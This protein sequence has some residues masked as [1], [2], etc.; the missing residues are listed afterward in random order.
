MCFICR[1]TLKTTT[2]LRQ[3]FTFCH[4][5]QTERFHCLKCD[6]YFEKV[7]SYIK[8]LKTLHEYETNSSHAV[9]QQC[10]YD[11]ENM[12][13]LDD[14][15]V[16]EEKQCLNAIENLPN[17]DDNSVYEEQC[18]FQDSN[19]PSVTEKCRTLKD[20]LIYT[21]TN[22]QTLNRKMIV[23]FLKE[24]SLFSSNIVN[25]LKFSIIDYLDDITNL[26]N[27]ET[28]HV[29]V[30]NLFDEALAS[31]DENISEHRLFKKFADSNCYIEPQEYIIAQDIQVKKNMLA[32]APIV[33]HHVPL[34]H[35][36]KHILEIPGVFTFALDYLSSNSSNDS[37]K[38]FCD[39]KDGNL[40]HS[41]KSNFVDKIVFPFFIY[42]DD[43]ECL[44]PL[45][46]HSGLHKLG[47]VYATLKCFPPEMLSALDNIYLT[48][49]FHADDRRNYKNSAVFD[50]LLKEIIDL[51]NNG[52]LINNGSET[53]QVYFVLGL[54]I[55]D[56]LAMHSLLGLV[57][58][59]SSNKVCRVCT[60]DK[61]Q[62]HTLTKESPE[63]LRNETQ[64]ED[65]CKSIKTFDS[66]L[67]EPCI[68]HKV[69]SFHLTKNISFDIC[70]DIWEGICS[71]DMAI[72]IEKFIYDDC[73]KFFDLNYLNDKIKYTAYVFD[74]TNKPPPI[75]RESLQKG[76]LKM[77][78]AETMT[79]IHY[80]R[81]YVGDCVPIDN[82]YWLLYLNLLHICNTV[83]S[84]CVSDPE[85][86]LL[87]SVIEEHH[88]RYCA[89]I[90]NLKPKYHY[91]L[92]YARTIR[93]SGNLNAMSTIRF[94]SKHSQLKSFAVNIKC[95][96]NFTKSIAIR[97]QI[98]Q[99]NILKDNSFIMCS[100]VTSSKKS[101]IPQQA[102]DKL[103]KVEN[104]PKELSANMPAYFCD[105]V[106][107]KGFK[108]SVGSIILYSNFDEVWPLYGEIEK[109]VF[110]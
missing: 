98:E 10:L 9:V 42:Y 18:Q 5:G 59:F 33:G 4:F 90:G 41:I 46:S 75:T 38:N 107:C 26:E 100:N 82:A 35:I 88:D 55:G 23:K 37:Y 13:N 61:L 76:Q 16:F 81:F 64:Y 67:K 87:D 34:S 103:K 62:L 36:F 39:F 99:C 102:F 58:S 51:E 106:L 20:D 25:V 105:F 43:F 78:A 96:K 56:N 48:L 60:C 68:W 53:V 108:Y 44:N 83:S 14:D 110:F 50:P 101:L 57:E 72:I 45:G 91:P 8:H 63:L 24:S 1:H 2:D 69:P 89:L 29:D 93:Q 28:L 104:F 22:C 66:G 80:F 3:H 94:E 85:I 47:A 77:S 27:F 73:Y 15:S 32:P 12:P 70:H 7:N 97:H 65:H 52:I 19:V 92:H 71:Y 95:R 84:K 21:V 31:L 109:I 17:V 49:L 11:I 30:K 54:I 6:R 86:D 74:R 40:W 79:F